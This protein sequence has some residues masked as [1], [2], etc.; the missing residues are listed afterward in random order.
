MLDDK[1]PESIAAKIL[2]TCDSKSNG[3][4][5][6]IFA[7]RDFIKENS[8]GQPPIPIISIVKELSRIC[9]EENI[10][11]IR[12]ALGNQARELDESDTLL[13]AVGQLLEYY[14]SQ[15]R[16][17]FSNDWKNADSLMMCAKY[18]GA[19]IRL[20]ETFVEERLTVQEI[21]EELEKIKLNILEKYKDGR[22]NEQSFVFVPGAFYSYHNEE[23]E[24][25]NKPLPSKREGSIERIHNLLNEN[26]QNHFDS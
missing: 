23:G 26:R 5:T 21:R 20:L 12:S 19:F 9:K 11:V 14:F 8:F 13:Q 22:T 6:G 16:T 25:T 1:T 3:V 18:I 15:V 7:L 4:L 10:E 24:E 2:K 17:E